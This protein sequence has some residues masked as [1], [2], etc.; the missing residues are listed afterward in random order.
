MSEETNL[1]EQQ[2]IFSLRT[3]DWDNSHIL[4][5]IG[6]AKFSEKGFIRLCHSLLEDAAILAIKQAK[7]W[8]GWAEIIEALAVLLEQHNFKQFIP[9][10]AAF[11]GSNIIDMGD[12]ID[13]NLRPCFGNSLQKLIDHNKTLQAKLDANLKKQMEEES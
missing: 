5:F 8:I 3:D 4:M 6:P 11:E 1:P 12:R 13:E 9:K 10:T 2:R 7:S